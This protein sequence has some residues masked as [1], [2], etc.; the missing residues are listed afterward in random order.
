MERH[1]RLTAAVLTLTLMTGAT[2]L[3]DP[4]GTISVK[5]N[6]VAGPPKT[7]QPQGSFTVT[8]T[9]VGDEYRV[10]VDYGTFGQNGAFVVWKGPDVYEVGI[11]S[12]IGSSNYDWG[13]TAVTT[14]TNPPAGLQARATLQW[15]PAVNVAWKDVNKSHTPCP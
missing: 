11:V 7:A 9:K 13:P 14:L 4:T 5:A 2:A 1:F 8:A 3:A 10:M 15:R 6:Y 12:S